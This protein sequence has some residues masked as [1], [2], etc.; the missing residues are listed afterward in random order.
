VRNLTLTNIS[1]IMET[2]ATDH[3]QINAVL[4]GDFLDV[5]RTKNPSGVYLVYDIVSINPAGDSGITYGIDVLICENVTE[6]N[7][8]TNSL[9]AQNECTFIGLD[10]L[11]VWQ[12]YNSVSFAD[13]DLIVALEKNWGM[14]PFEQRF[15]S[16]YSGVQMNINI[17]TGYSYARCTVPVFIEG[18]GTFKVGTTFIVA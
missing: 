10:L 5:D 16:L 8:S 12:N 6:I 13:K 1:S 3:K 9:Y 14:Q 2:F 11:A 17:T 4:R 15:D 18:I 7:N